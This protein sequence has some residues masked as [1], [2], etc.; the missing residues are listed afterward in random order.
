MITRQDYMNGKNTHREYYAQFVT[1]DTIL[2]VKRCIGETRIVESKDENLNDIHLNCWDNIPCYGLNAKLNECGDSL[3][4]A[5]KNCI[6]KEAA[7]QIK[8]AYQQC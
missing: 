6:H 2:T 1:A 8:E 7:R 3:T 4:L 5:G